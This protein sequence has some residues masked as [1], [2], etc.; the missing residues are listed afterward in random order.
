MGPD[1]KPFMLENFLPLANIFHTIVGTG[2]KMKKEA[3]ILWEIV[4]PY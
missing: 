2:Y 1:L 4:L 3:S